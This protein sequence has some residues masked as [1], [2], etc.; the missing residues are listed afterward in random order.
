MTHPVGTN[1]NKHAKGHAGA[2][3]LVLDG[4]QVKARLIAERIESGVP[5]HVDWVRFTVNLRNAPMPSV[6]VLFPEEDV[7]PLSVWDRD[8]RTVRIQR[9]RKVLRFIPDVDFSP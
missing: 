5:V 3:S 7:E 8:E 6:D 9:L 1:V 4:N 2:C